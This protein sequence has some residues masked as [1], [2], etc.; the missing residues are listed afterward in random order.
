MARKKAATPKTSKTSLSPRRS[1]EQLT[2]P[3]GYAELLDEIKGRIRSAQIKAVLAVN[4]ELIVLYWSI[5]RDIVQRQRREGWGKSV[6]E[7][8]G[9]DIQAAFPG[10]A[11]F[12]ARNI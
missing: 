2:I 11:G 8:L 4:S 10:I 12:S 1:S 7:R 6:V 9:R 5:G 3:T